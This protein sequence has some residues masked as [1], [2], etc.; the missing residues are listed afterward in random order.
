MT[1]L[2]TSAS[3]ERNRPG[4][5]FLSRG[6]GMQLRTTHKDPRRPYLR[7]G[8]PTRG[9]LGLLRPPEGILDQN[10]YTYREFVPDSRG[11][12]PWELN[13]EPL[14]RISSDLAAPTKSNGGGGRGK[15]RGIRNVGAAAETPRLPRGLRRRPP[16]MDRQGGI[17]FKKEWLRP[18]P[19]RPCPRR[20][21]A[22]RRRRHAVPVA[23]PGCRSG[24]V[25]SLPP[26]PKSYPRFGAPPPRFRHSRERFRTSRRPSEAIQHASMRR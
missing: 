2:Y 16:T 8:R 12:G 23:F 20:R 4:P 18:A 6:T 3:T 15:A 26:S 9:L 22:L 7:R 24:P 1:K 10:W 21:H 25:T 14:T 5:E 17:L 19:I 13:D 11:Q